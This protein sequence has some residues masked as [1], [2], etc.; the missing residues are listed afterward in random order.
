M[1]DLVVCFSAE[2]GISIYVLGVKETCIKKTRS[3]HFQ[4]L[5]SGVNFISGP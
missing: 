4:Y 3:N 2:I 5:L 1:A